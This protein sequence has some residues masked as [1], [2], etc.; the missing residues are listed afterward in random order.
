MYPQ[1]SPLRLKDDDDNQ[2]VWGYQK[3]I[4]LLVETF[5]FV[6]LDPYNGK[7]KLFF[8]FRLQVTSS[9]DISRLSTT[10]GFLGICHGVSI[11]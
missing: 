11:P 10:E 5:T 3:K 7:R 9:L 6:P 1:Y 8:V 4:W 2:D